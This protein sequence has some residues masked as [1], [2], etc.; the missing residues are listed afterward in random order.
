M[1]R[2]RSRHPRPGS[3]SSAQKQD[4]ARD[5]AV[6]SPFPAWPACTTAVLLGPRLPLPPDRG[7]PRRLRRPARPPPTSCPPELSFENPRAQLIARRRR[8]D[9]TGHTASSQQATCPNAR[10]TRIEQQLHLRVSRA[11]PSHVLN[12][13]P[14]PSLAAE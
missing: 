2:T 6:R 10:P 14:W 1:T 12:C 8:R 4:R 3:P 5:R 9:E 13:S 11:P 7:S